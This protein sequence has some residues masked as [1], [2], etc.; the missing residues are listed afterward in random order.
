MRTVC[1]TYLQ[2]DRPRVTDEAW[3]QV[4]DPLVPAAR[5]FEMPNWN[6]TMSS[7]NRTVLGM[8]CYCAPSSDDPIWS[9]SD[10]DLADLCAASLVDPLGWLDAAHQARLL[11]VVRLP[12]AYPSPD[13]DQLPAMDAAAKML[14]QIKG[15]HLARGSAV[16]DAIHAGEICARTALSRSR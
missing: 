15:L 5:I 8:E 3:V 12:A 2:I 16:I 11:E 14:A 9:R 7:G 6:A 4:D 13:L 10:A 1:V